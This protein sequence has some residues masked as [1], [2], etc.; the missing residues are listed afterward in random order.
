MPSSGSLK[1]TLRLEICLV[2][3]LLGGGNPSKDA[4]LLFRIETR[5]SGDELLRR[6]RNKKN[7]VKRNTFLGSLYPE[8]KKQKYLNQPNVF[9]KHSRSVGCMLSKLKD[10]YNSSNLGFYWN[11]LHWIVYVYIMH[12]QQSNK[13]NVKNQTTVPDYFF[14]RKVKVKVSTYAM[15]VLSCTAQENWVHTMLRV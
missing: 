10:N 9:G 11:L 7:V 6:H 8:S 4:L 13:H 5:P 12:V 2:T 14:W 3:M 1:R 15:T